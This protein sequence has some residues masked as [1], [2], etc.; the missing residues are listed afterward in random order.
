MKYKLVIFDLDG[1]ILDTLQD[2]G[3][4]VNYALEKNNLPLRSIEEVRAFVG[5][6]I[7]LLIDR[8]VPVNTPDDVTQKVFDDFKSHYA[9]HN[10]DT[11]RP[12]E[13][14]KDV[15]ESLK[16]AGIKTAV[17]SN[18]TDPA[19]QSLIKEYFPGLFLYVA[20]EQEGIKR[21]PAP[22]AVFS[23]INE[24]GV[25]ITDTV[26]VGDSEV[27]I[28]TAENA[29]TDCICVSWGFR[30]K[31]QLISE[32]ADTVISHIKELKDMLLK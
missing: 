21:K 25:S 29:G 2:L 15:I 9:V 27:D 12:Y 13:G 20:G 17:I 7:R 19:V 22:D 5:N 11:T 14:I 26:Y 4:S 1:T 24:L 28:F 3:N 23:A 10:A 32:G 18:K 30:D 16:N 8:A 31:E 6:G